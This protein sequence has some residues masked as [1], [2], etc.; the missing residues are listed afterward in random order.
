M[1]SRVMCRNILHTRYTL[2]QRCF[3]G[4]RL[5]FCGFATVVS[6]L[7]RPGRFFSSPTAV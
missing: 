1:R 4:F 3:L 5:V 2:C 6:F 7:G